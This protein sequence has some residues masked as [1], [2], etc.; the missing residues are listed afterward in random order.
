MALPPSSAGSVSDS[1]SS[2]DAPTT[3]AFA[4]YVCCELLVDPAC[5]TGN[6]FEACQTV[7]FLEACQTGISLEACQTGILLEACQTGI[8]L[9]AC[10]TGILLEA[11]AYLLSPIPSRVRGLFNLSPASNLPLSR[12]G[13]SMLAS[14]QSRITRSSPCVLKASRVPSLAAP[15]A[16]LNVP[17]PLPLG[18]IPPPA[19]GLASPT[20]RSANLPRRTT[21]RLNALAKNGNTEESGNG[22]YFLL[23]ANVLV[24]VADHV[25]HYP[26]LREVLYLHHAAP[27]WWQ[28]VTHSFC[29]GSLPHLSGNLFNLL[30]GK[31]GKAPAKATQLSVQ[32]VK[33][34]ARNA[35]R[36]SKR[37]QNHTSTSTRLQTRR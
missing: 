33:S 18:R 11:S 9:E 30:E 22:V 24:F 36:T 29:H 15:P 27:Q 23:L 10:Q 8:S 26:G 5:Q 20:L 37:N 3:A 34:T 2:A 25:L 16:Q 6:F 28:F 12:T 13:P 31:Q 17:G 4:C 19:L 35:H 21:H 1:A 7:I 32:G 14:A